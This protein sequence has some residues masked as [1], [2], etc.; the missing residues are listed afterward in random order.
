MSSVPNAYRN[1]ILVAFAV[2]AT[3]NA[4]DFIYYGQHLSHLAAVLGLSVAMFGVIK[5]K[6]AVANVGA[7]LAISGIAAKYT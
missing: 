3:T 6:A 2:F 4:I 7:L 1:A 5:G